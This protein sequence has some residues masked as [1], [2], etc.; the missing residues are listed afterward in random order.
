MSNAQSK[1]SKSK[2]EV[3]VLY[4]NL[5]GKLYAFTEING[6]VFFG[7]IPVKQ[8]AKAATAKNKTKGSDKNKDA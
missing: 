6:Q 4:Q 3:N 2:K 7:R 1:K 8:S 5:N